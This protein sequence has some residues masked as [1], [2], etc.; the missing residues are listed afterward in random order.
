MHL[1][2]PLV[3][4][5]ELALWLLSSVYIDMARPHCLRL[6]RQWMAWALALAEASEGSS[7]P[8][9]MA[10]IAMTTSNS[11]SVKA[12]VEED[13]LRRFLWLRSIS[14]ESYK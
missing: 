14:I 6:P 2:P 9:R 1:D 12:R 13:D 10:M 4:N 11:M 8:A 5:T 7:R 3:M